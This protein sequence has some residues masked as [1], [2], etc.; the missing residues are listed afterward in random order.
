MLLIEYL[1]YIADE[2]SLSFEEVYDRC[3]GKENNEAYFDIQMR[4]GELFNCCM[5]LKE[6]E[7]ALLCDYIGSGELKFIAIRRDEISRIGFS[8]PDVIDIYLD[9][10]DENNE[11]LI[12]LVKLEEEDLL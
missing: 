1:K 12:D 8:N 2:Q 6:S 10:L 4:N 5:I 9:A 3:I 7:D 11:G